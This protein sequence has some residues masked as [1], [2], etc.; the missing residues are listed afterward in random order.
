MKEQSTKEFVYEIYQFEIDMK[1]LETDS[2]YSK[3]VANRMF[4]EL[5]EEDKPTFT[6][7]QYKMVHKD[8]LKFEGSDMAALEKL[9]C[10][11]NIDHPA[12]YKGRSLSVSDVVKLNDKYYYCQPFG[13]DE[14]TV[15]DK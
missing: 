14:I 7:N 9:F 6:L 3:V 2:E 15:N 5:S 4:R 12:G 8:V 13:W 11:Y 1:R 10:K